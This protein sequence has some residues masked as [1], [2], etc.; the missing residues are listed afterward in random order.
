M[1]LRGCRA[2]PSF[3]SGAAAHRAV[4]GL[5]PGAR[6]RTPEGSQAT[7]K[8]AWHARAVQTGRIENGR[9]RI[10]CYLAGTLVAD[11][12]DPVLVWEKPQYPA[13]L[14]PI[15]DV[16]ATLSPTGEVRELPVLGAAEVHDIIAVG[17]TAPGAAARCGV[18]GR[19]LVR[20]G[21]AAMDEWLE[22]DEPVHTHPRDPYTR[23][24]ILA[25]SRRITVEI[26]GIRVA[27]SVRPRILFETGLPPRYYLPLSDVRMDLLSPSATT[28][29]CPYKG[30]ATYWSAAVRDTRYADIA[31][32]YRA[33]LPESQKIAGLVCFFDVRVDVLLD[34]VPPERPRTHFA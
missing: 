11:T 23:V 21:W 2:H 8:A 9:K 10:R 32:T 33:P 3:A 28:S 26:D 30:I 29:P 18:H 5:T 25:S 16:R 13:Y 4:R 20:F 17:A 22:E 1:V 6:R 7:G 27:D 12:V 19:D 31:W 24:D 14:L 15:V 34:G